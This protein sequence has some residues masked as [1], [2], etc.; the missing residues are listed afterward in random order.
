MVKCL[1][2]K[3]I[4]LQITTTGIDSTKP[5]NA[6]Y[7]SDNSLTSSAMGFAI[8]LRSC[9]QGESFSTSGAC[10]ECE[11]EIEYSLSSQDT[12]GDCL[13][14]QTN[15]MYCYG[16]SDIGPKPGYWR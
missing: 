3:H 11:A 7:L 12:P 6:E 16:G 8:A 2:T 1:N 4:D 5:S 15:K 10:I 13:A 14:C 9:V